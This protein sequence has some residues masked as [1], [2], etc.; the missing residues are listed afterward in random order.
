MMSDNDWS[1][2]ALERKAKELANGPAPSDRD[3][4]QSLLLLIAQ[5]VAQTK[6]EH[7]A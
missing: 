7:K 6:R 4:I 5:Y 3:R 2:E 1:P